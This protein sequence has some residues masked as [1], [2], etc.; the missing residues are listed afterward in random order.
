[1]L[2][3]QGAAA[4]RGEIRPPENRAAPAAAAPRSL[5]DTR[6]LRDALEELREAARLLEGARRG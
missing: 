2:R 1:M 3:E 5:P 6:E 4:V